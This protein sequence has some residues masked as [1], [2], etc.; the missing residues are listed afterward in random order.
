MGAD[1]TE[2]RATGEAP[3]AGPTAGKGSG[4]DTESQTRPGPGAGESFWRR[5]L[6]PAR[7]SLVIACGV[8][9]FVL[10]TQLQATEGVGASLEVEREE[11]LARILAN[12]SSETDRLQSE[13]NDLRLTLFAFEESAEQEDLAL[14]SLEERLEDLSI[15]A[16]T[17]AAEGE[18][19]VL[20]IDDPDGVVGPAALVDAVQELRDAGAEAIAVNDTRL[21]VSSSFVSRNQ[22]LVVDGQ[23]LDPPYRVSAIGPAESMDGALGIPGGVI[24]TLERFEDVAAD[25]EIRGELRVPARAEPAPFVFGEPVAPED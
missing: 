23:P 2:T 21:V 14:R 22:R 9:G 25:V 4:D 19:V 1:M 15:L 6:A 5:H 16:G 17:V 7:V 12:L 13:Y 24:D 10:A 11:D 3:R 18:G 8:V 20:I